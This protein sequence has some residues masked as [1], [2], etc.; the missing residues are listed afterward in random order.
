MDLAIYIKFPLFS[1]RKVFSCFPSLCSYRR[2][3]RHVTGSGWGL[4][5]KKGNLSRHNVRPRDSHFE[6]RGTNHMSA[7]IHHSSTS[8]IIMLLT[9]L[10]LTSLLT[11]VTN[12]TTESFVIQALNTNVI[13]P[14]RRPSL[15]LFLCNYWVVNVRLHPYPAKYA[16]SLQMFIPCHDGPQSA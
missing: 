16:K 9:C 1:P 6:M 8:W 15:R 4:Q 5:K 3:R 12:I 10:V 14:P 7:F 2:R 11:K 13:I